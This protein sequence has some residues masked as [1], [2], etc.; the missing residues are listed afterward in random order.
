[1][2]GYKVKHTSTVLTSEAKDFFA[3]AVARGIMAS[4]D[5]TFLASMGNSSGMAF[6]A[7][8]DKGEVVGIISYTVL[9]FAKAARIDLI[10]VDE[11]SRKLGVFAALFTALKGYLERYGVAELFAD[12]P[13]D[14]TVLCDLLERRGGSVITYRYVIDIG[15]GDGDNGEL[16]GPAH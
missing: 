5:H 9:E 4:S 12:V 3:E 13:G 7:T 8:A 1:M 14:D 11:A 16:L 6:Y 2:L 15:N 10:Y